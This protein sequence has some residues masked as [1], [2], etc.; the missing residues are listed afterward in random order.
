MGQDIDQDN[1]VDRNKDADEER[2]MEVGGNADVAENEDAIRYLCA[3]FLHRFKSP[4]EI[5]NKV[6]FEDILLR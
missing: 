1:I 6:V 4:F 3:A 5:L 2:Y